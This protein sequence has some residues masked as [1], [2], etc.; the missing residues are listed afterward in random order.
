M[1]KKDTAISCKLNKQY[2]LR[3]FMFILFVQVSQVG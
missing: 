3:T 1:N 2:M